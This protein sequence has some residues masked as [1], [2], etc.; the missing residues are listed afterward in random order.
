MLEHRKIVIYTNKD[1]QFMK[2]WFIPMAPIYYYYKICMCSNHVHDII[3]ILCTNKKIHATRE[4]DQC[5]VPS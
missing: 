4:K 1:D 3:I 2:V 5:M